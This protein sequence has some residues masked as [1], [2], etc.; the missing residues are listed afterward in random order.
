VKNQD[1]DLNLKLKKAGGNVL[2]TPDILSYY[3]LSPDLG[4]REFF[5]RILLMALG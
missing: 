4:F 3:Y 1:T 5:L 2:L